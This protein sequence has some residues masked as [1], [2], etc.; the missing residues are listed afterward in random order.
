MAPA[1]PTLV[2]ELES[3]PYAEKKT[4]LLAATLPADGPHHPRG[5][6]LASV[7]R[8]HAYG[9]TLLHLARRVLN[10]WTPERIEQQALRRAADNPPASVIAQEV[11]VFTVAHQAWSTILID[12][13]PVVT[14]GFSGATKARLIDQ[15]IGDTIL[16]L[17]RRAAAAEARAMDLRLR[18][19]VEQLVNAV[20]QQ[21]VAS[22]LGQ[23]ID[24]AL[25]SG[26]ESAEVKALLEKTE[27]MVAAMSKD[28]PK[29]S[30]D[31]E[32]VADII[33]GEWSRKEIVS[34]PYIERAKAVTVGVGKAAASAF[35]KEIVGRLLRPHE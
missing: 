14:D 12:W 3:D 10:Y 35:I 18:F 29:V 1:P 24:Q 28:F 16:A 2:T 22:K 31:T 25:R 20:R 21:D 34:G 33:Y 26:A 8:F 5:G 32:I 6:E 11:A 23:V 30:S 13:I 19:G 9:K 27:A 4:A 7:E 15:M 17:E